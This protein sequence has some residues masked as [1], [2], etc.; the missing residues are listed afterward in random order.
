[1]AH[2]CGPRRRDV[3]WL[4][5][6]RYN[7]AGTYRDET[8]VANKRHHKGTRKRVASRAQVDTAHVCSLGDFGF[9]SLGSFR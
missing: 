2:L 3:V 7:E 4:A 8:D 6:P 9:Q 1:M 5:A